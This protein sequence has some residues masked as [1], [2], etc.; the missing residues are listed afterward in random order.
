[1]GKHLVWLQDILLEL[2]AIKLGLWSSNSATLFCEAV[3]CVLAMPLSWMAVFRPRGLGD[4]DVFVHPSNFRADSESVPS[5]PIC[6]CTLY[7]HV[8]IAG[9]RSLSNCKIAEEPIPLYYAI[10]GNSVPL[11]PYTKDQEDFMRNKDVVLLLQVIS[12]ICCYVCWV[13]IMNGR[14]S[15]KLLSRAPPPPQNTGTGKHVFELHRCRENGCSISSWSFWVTLDFDGANTLHDNKLFFACSQLE[16][17]MAKTLGN[18]LPTFQV[19][20]HRTTC[21]TKQN[22]WDQLTWVNSCKKFFLCGKDR[23]WALLLDSFL[24]LLKMIN[25]IASWDHLVNSDIL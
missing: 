21:C 4:S 15:C 25:V 6:S 18:C 8:H 2:C 12:C 22:S 9:G 16:S 13:P 5:W 23:K 17:L 14:S 20:G 3:D 7:H 24:E 10:Q 1:M 11:V 19:F